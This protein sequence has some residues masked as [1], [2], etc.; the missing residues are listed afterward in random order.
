MN[1]LEPNQIEKYHNDGFLVIRNVLSENEC[2]DLKK[3]LKEEIQKGK[4]S[5]KKSSGKKKDHKE[6]DDDEVKYIKL[7]IKFIFFKNRK[8]IVKTY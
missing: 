5:L 3:N 7:N 1:F 8:I 6:Y 2:D 4:D